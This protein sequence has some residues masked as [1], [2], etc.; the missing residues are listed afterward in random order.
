MTPLK[1][2]L[3]YDKPE[4]FQHVNNLPVDA[5]DEFEPDSTI[6]IMQDA[7]HFLGYESVLIGGPHSMFKK[8]PLVDVIWNIA[9]GY[10]SRNREAWVP[11]LCELYEIPFL[12]S[13]AHTLSTSLD[14]HQTKLIAQSIGIPTSYWKI[15]QFNSQLISEWT[16]FPAFI[17]PRYEGTAKG[18][19]KDSIVN[20]KDELLNGVEQLWKIYQQDVIIEKCLTGPEF[21]CAVHSTPLIATPILERGLDVDTRIGIHVLEQ[22]GEQTDEYWISNES[23]DRIERDIQQW[24][25]DLCKEMEV[26]DYARLDFKCDEEGRAYFLEINPL[27]TFAI[28]NTFAILAELKGCDYVE[29]L[30]S[31]LKSGLERLGVV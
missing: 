4:D 5:F 12:G 31:I 9:E 3:C 15:A 20:T 17:K 18:I 28:D 6:Q 21:T 7:I 8:K 30:S 26:L 1:I 25:V 23:H 19:T 14:K 11:I 13:D 16:D 24:S 22:K 29:Y 2:G 27:P 10:G